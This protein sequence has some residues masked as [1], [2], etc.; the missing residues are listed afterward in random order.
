MMWTLL[1][2]YIYL[3]IYR[4]EKQKEWADDFNDTNHQNEIFWITE[5]MV[6]EKQ[7]ITR[8]NCLKG[9]SGTVII[10]E[11]GIKDLWKEYMEKLTNKEWTGS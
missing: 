3:F 7:D 4:K 10:D 8:S 5:Q 9:V 2:K 6:K 11:K 1:N